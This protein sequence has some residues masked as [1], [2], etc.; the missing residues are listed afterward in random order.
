MDANIIP[1]YISFSYGIFIILKSLH[2][3]KVKKR[4][5]KVIR[6]AAVGGVIDSA[7]D[8]SWG[9]IITTSFIRFWN[10]P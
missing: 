5:W 8:A 10:V 2:I 7:G 4:I 1:C 3:I 6:I 9:P